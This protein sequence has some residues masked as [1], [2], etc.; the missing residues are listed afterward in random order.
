MGFRLGVFD[1]ICAQRNQRLC[2]RYTREIPQHVPFYP[3]VWGSSW[4]YSGFFHDQN[5]R[6]SSG[7]CVLQ[8]KREDK[9][10]LNAAWHTKIVNTGHDLFV[11]V[12]TFVVGKN[13]IT[14]NWSSMADNAI[15]RGSIGV[16]G[17]PFYICGSSTYA[18]LQVCSNSLICFIMCVL[19]LKCD[20]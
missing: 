15:T 7:V 18:L 8:S 20:H 12:S 17:S 9:H 10:G 16:L 6:N 13:P 19:P 4:G 5:N 1:F 14:P 11:F 3:P 2:H